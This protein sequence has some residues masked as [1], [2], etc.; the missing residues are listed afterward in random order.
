[1]GA[2]FWRW[3]VVKECLKMLNERSRK[4]KLQRLPAEAVLVL[5]AIDWSESL[6]EAA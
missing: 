5:Q 4:R 6:G 2:D 3:E 1:M